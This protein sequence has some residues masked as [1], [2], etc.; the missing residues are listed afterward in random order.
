[1]DQKA[2]ELL[3]QA[4]LK[5]GRELNAIVK[6]IGD[7]EK[8]IDD[9][10]AAA[11]RGENAADKLKAAQA[12]LAAVQ[13][14]LGDRGDT[15]RRFQSLTE[16]IEK[17]GAAVIKAK[18]RLEAYQAKVGESRNDKQQAQV[19]KLTAAYEAQQKSLAQLKSSSEQLGQG[20]SD[21]GIDVTRLA[22]AQ[23]ELADQEVRAK[24]LLN[25]VNQELIDYSSNIDRARE[26]TRKL[27]EEQAKLNRLQKGNETDANLGR[28][29]AAAARKAAEQ[30]AF[31]QQ[32]QNV[33]FRANDALAR[34]KAA[35]ESE[36]LAI[37]E[38]EDFMR[39]YAESKAAA[40]K[41]DAGFRKTADEAQAA[42][43]QYSTLV[44]ASSDL[45]PRVVSLRDALDGIINPSAKARE[46]LAGVESQIKEISAVIAGSQGA[47][48]DYS[49]QFKNL[50]QAQK[51]IQGQ[52]GLI[53]DFRNQ[54]A[55]LKSARSEFTAARGQV[56][57]YAAALRAGGD[58]G[59]QFT[60]PMA[61]AQIRLRQAA[62][63][64]RDQV[65]A[66]RESRDALRQAGIDSRNLADAQ[67]RLVAATRQSGEAL[68]ALGAAAEANG[69]A[70]NKSGKGFSLFRDEGRTTLSITQR[71]RGEIL[72]LTTAYIGV[73]AAIGFASDSLKAFNEIQGLKSTFAFALGTQDTD[74]IG[75]E[76]AYVRDQAERLGISFE[77]GS[78]GYAKFAAAAVRS[79][80]SVQET[81]F[82]FEAFS[83]VARTIN[84]TPEELNGLFLA[85]GQSFSKG[86]IQAEE[87]RQQIGERLPGAFAFAQEALKSKFPDLNKALEEGKVGAENMLLIAESVR[88]AAQGGLAQ[89]LKSLDAEQ[90]R[91]NNSVLFFKQQVAEAGFADAYIALLKQLTEF[92]RSNDGKEF[93]KTLGEIAT[94]FVNGISAVVK[95]K[96]EIGLLALTFGGIVASRAIVTTGA[97]VSALAGSLTAASVAAAAFAPIALTLVGAFRALSAAAAAFIAGFAIGKYLSDQFV[98]VRL[99]GI[100][101]V[102]TFQKMW[103]LLTAGAAE[104]WERLPNLA[105][106]AFK[107]MINNATLFF[108]TFLK[109]FEVGAKA[110]GLTPIA[111][112]IGKA[113]D[114]ITLNQSR[115]VSSTVKAIRSQM[116][117]DLAEIENLR[118]AQ[119]AEAL[120]TP[121]LTQK[122]VRDRSDSRFFRDRP[123]N[124]RTIKQPLDPKD[125]E[126]YAKEVEG[127]LDKINAINAK[128]LNGANETLASQIQSFLETTKP[129][130][131]EIEKLKPAERKDAQAKLARAEKERVLDI[132]QQFNEKIL[133][134]Q[135]ALNKK[136]NGLEA[137]NGKKE[138]DE[139][140]ARLDAVTL[141]YAETF[142]EI[143]KIRDKALNNRTDVSMTPD[144]AFT[145]AAEKRANAALAEAQNIE[146]VKFLRE[147]LQ[148]REESIND[149]LKARQLSIQAIEDRVAAGNLNR[150]AAD[151][152]ILSVVAQ[153]QPAIAAATQAAREFALANAAAF[154]PLRLQ[155]FLSLLDKA[156]GSGDVLNATFNRTQKIINDGIGQG[157]SNAFDALYDSVGRLTQGTTDWGDV[158]DSIGK[159]ILQT[160]ASILKE[161]AGLIIKQQV[162]NALRSFGVISGAVA[163]SGA[164]VGVSSPSR[165]RAVSSA[166]FA[167][168]PRYHTGGVV[169][170]ASNEYPA[171]LQK[172]EEVLAASDPRNIMNGGGKSAQSPSPANRFVLVD[173]RARIP[174]AMNSPEGEQVTLVHLRKNIATLRQ[175]LK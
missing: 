149:V 89:A 37:K 99:F 28:Q 104:F 29:Q 90:Q 58:A 56:A 96:D 115:G 13:K 162:L 85:I 110:L 123:L 6:S 30:N 130:R 160:L 74:R 98:Q 136:L 83:E 173:D 133:A 170:L 14:E 86:K 15:V 118:A 70:V 10:A 63:A 171:I 16:A 46:T 156:R 113:L 159:S 141:S 35:A 88:K 167:N 112:S 145:D 11:K 114:T 81:R 27:A 116:L 92:F 148:K 36:L 51:A 3:I 97:A 5:G 9:Q 121:D 8:A 50:S 117:N 4:K 119:E 105:V 175:L 164:V 49:E 55:V 23:K 19:L 111:E 48:K 93:A 76:I 71:L 157:V 108:R 135:D 2:V 169:G 168:A 143:Q 21:A 22:G 131:R 101:M 79:G 67:T 132:T 82:I 124:V 137:A 155:E 52:A 122:A 125:A 24:G 12:A 33:S 25:K 102:A 57:Q 142:A 32:A 59:A 94:A 150:D 146:R 7:L 129:L 73:Q 144:T 41:Q 103:V 31:D 127:I 47:V 106:D 61:E 80:A 20:L 54:T 66:T 151:T 161:I 109:I 45:R 100:D 166:W 69:N 65:I 42:A 174:E 60:K 95:Y 44:R 172:N 107:G 75:K 43:K 152:Q 38:S 84:L 26:A 53:D 39:R 68:K 153:A 138:K 40:A 139:L 91:F 17:Q 77:K 78:K 87:L 154:D 18:D 140:Q 165:T 147:Q 163:H 34:N 128:T 120:K 158:F 134:E 72:A 1:M 126:K 64:L 62:A